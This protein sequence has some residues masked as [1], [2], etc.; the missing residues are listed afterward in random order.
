VTNGLRKAAGLEMSMDHGLTWNL[1]T[2]AYGNP[3][4][5]ATWPLLAAACINDGAVAGELSPYPPFDRASIQIRLKVPAGGMSLS[6]SL[7]HLEVS[8]TIL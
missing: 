1:F 4:D 8:G 5:P 6:E 7:F 2:R 3:E